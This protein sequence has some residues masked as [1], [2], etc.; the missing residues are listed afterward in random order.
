MKNLQKTNTVEFLHPFSVIFNNTT[1]SN[2]PEPLSTNLKK[3]N[4][5]NGTAAT[6]LASSKQKLNSLQNQ[7]N[8][9]SI[10][11]AQKTKIITIIRNS[12]TTDT[13]SNNIAVE[14]KHFDIDTQEGLDAMELQSYLTYLEKAV[15]KLL[16]PKVA[17]RI[18]ALETDQEKQLALDIITMTPEL[19][20]LLEKGEIP[21]DVLKERADTIL[22]LKKAKKTLGEELSHE[23]K[24]IDEII[25]SLSEKIH[26]IGTVSTEINSLNT[27]GSFEDSWFGNTDNIPYA[28]Y[29][30]R[31]TGDSN[32]GVGAL[33]SKSPEKISNPDQQAQ[34]DR[35]EQFI[36]SFENA[37]PDPKYKTALIKSLRL[38]HQ[39]EVAKAAKNL[40]ENVLSNFNDIDALSIMTDDKGLTKNLRAIGTTTE[41][42]KILR[43]E[44]KENLPNSAKKEIE[45]SMKALKPAA[46]QTAQKK[47]EAIMEALKG[48]P[49]GLQLQRKGKDQLIE[50]I[51]ASIILE[52]SMDAYITKHGSENLG[53]SLKA[54]DDMK[55]LDGMLNFSDKNVKLTAEIASFAV[56]MVATT[57]LTAGIGTLGAL[58]IN[59]ARAGRVANL[60]AKTGR[61]GS[62]GKK[63]QAGLEG[64][65]KAMQ[66]V[67]TLAKTTRTGKVTAQATAFTGTEMAREAFTPGAEKAS[68]VGFAEKFAKNAILFATLEGM[69]MLAA[70]VTA[71]LGLNNPEITRKLGAELG[72][73]GINLT[74]DTIGMY[75]LHVLETKK[76]S[77]TKE[78]FGSLVAMA[79]AFRTGGAAAKAFPWLKKN[80]DAFLKKRKGTDLVTTP[81]SSLKPQPDANRTTSPKPQG[82]AENVPN[83]PVTPAKR[84][85]LQITHQPI[86]PPRQVPQIAP[87]A[88]PV[89]SQKPNTT[90][91]RP[92]K[93][94]PLQIA[95]QPVTRP[96]PNKPLNKPT[97]RITTETGPNNKEQLSNLKK[98]RDKLHNSI[99]EIEATVR[100]RLK[101]KKSDPEIERIIKEG[102]LKVSWDKLKTLNKKIANLA[103][104]KRISS[105]EKTAI[106]A[107]LPQKSIPFVQ[108]EVALAKTLPKAQQ[109]S[110][111]ADFAK[112]LKGKWKEGLGIAASL[113]AISLFTSELFGNEDEQAKAEASKVQDQL[114]REAQAQQNTAGTPNPTKQEDAQEEVLTPEPEQEILRERIGSTISVVKDD[115]LYRI[116]RK[117][118]NKIEWGTKVH[119]LSNEIKTNK[120]TIMSQANLIEPGQKIQVVENKKTNKME[121]Y[122]LDKDQEIPEKDLTQTQSTT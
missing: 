84:Q 19:T 94:E 48:T 118:S 115:H 77:L 90:S 83:P 67:S 112:K 47:Y 34:K 68:M 65:G 89:T 91:V 120:P 108:K 121:V 7:I 107:G 70:K 6:E 46:E 38:L 87:P 42:G 102:D 1:P 43:E 32:A 9:S 106:E 80:L 22:K 39:G 27:D 88:K 74:A 114:R 14:A 85:P 69:G 93:G 53:D 35:L 16:K 3:E 66:K 45:D 8:Q 101:G 122:V 75:G 54:Y 2:T 51:T 103:Q 56:S 105:A 44:G 81:Q 11:E 79:A 29:I 78:E 100:K 41:A 40:Q 12:L 109:K 33:I 99:K 71:R 104:P 60:A 55:G 92:A 15:E 113:A 58:A 96:K 4:L 49:E 116:T 37:H 82:S 72:K 5:E 57:I 86:T 36:T 63:A 21:I 119:Y 64:T 59:A 73:L 50:G 23:K 52:K 97:K 17:E 98:E 28:E 26:Q 25:K 95:H 18:S 30:A 24:N 76:I 20:K 110:R 111:I 13:E 117:V 10:D 62:L 31:I 61:M